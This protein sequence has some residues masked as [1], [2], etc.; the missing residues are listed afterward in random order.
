MELITAVRLS[1]I[2]IYKTSNYTFLQSLI[3][4]V[5]FHCD[6]VLACAMLKKLP[7]YKDAEIIRT[8]D[9][10]LLEECDIVVDV[11]GEFNVSMKNIKFLISGIKSVKIGLQFRLL[12]GF[13]IFQR[14]GFVNL[15]S[16][17]K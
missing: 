15:F 5:A 7:E 14:Q 3:F 12:I 8:R 2:L 6:E 11:G 16:F 4:L 13:Q 17:L 1:K 9:Q 10:K